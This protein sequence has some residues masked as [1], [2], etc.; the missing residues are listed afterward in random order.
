[1]ANNFVSTGSRITVGQETGS[2]ILITDK[3]PY[4]KSPYGGLS[5]LNG[6]TFFWLVLYSISAF[7]FP[8]S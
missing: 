6:P 8:M 7:W 1:M 4:E 5:I 2:G 3:K